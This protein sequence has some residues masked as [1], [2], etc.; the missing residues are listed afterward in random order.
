MCVEFYLILK[1]A[2][3]KQALEAHLGFCGDV[4]PDTS[5][6]PTTREQDQPSGVSSGL[7][8]S[9]VYLI[10]AGEAKQLANAS[11]LR[12]KRLTTSFASSC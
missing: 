11:S 2:G 1:A 12:C 6:R 4:R 9:I 10:M 8:C 3:A 7:A 5:E